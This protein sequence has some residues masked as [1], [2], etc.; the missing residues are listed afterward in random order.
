MR[1]RGLDASGEVAEPFL[2]RSELKMAASGAYIFLRGAGFVSW[3][4]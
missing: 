4:A 2:R 1:N 3:R